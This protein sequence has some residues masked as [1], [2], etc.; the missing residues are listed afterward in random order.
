MGVLV[1]KKAPS[2]KAAAVINGGE[3]VNDFS[4]VHQNFMLFKRNWQNSRHVV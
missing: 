4:F 2:F 3:I 1:G